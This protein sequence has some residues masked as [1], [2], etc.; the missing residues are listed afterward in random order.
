M[1]IY[2]LKNDKRGMTLIEMIISLVILSILMTST[3]GMITS[4]MSIF[5]STSLAALDRMVGNSVY[6]TLE[7]SLRYATHLTISNT[8]D[9]TLTSQSFYVGNV[10][11]ATNS[12][13]VMY[14]AEGDTNYLSLYSP[15]FYGNRSVQYSVTEVGSDGRHV[16]ITVKIFRDGEAVYTKEATIKCVNLSLIKTEAD[17]NSIE[18]RIPTSDRANAVNQYL[19]FSVDE[20]LLS[21]GSD[22]WALEYK[23]NDYMRGYNAI[24]AEYYG[25]LSAAENLVREAINKYGKDPGS[26]MEYG[27]LQ[28]LAL[29][30]DVAI[31]GDGSNDYYWEG[32]DAKQYNN[33]WAHYREEMEE[34]LHFKPDDAGFATTNPYYGVV[35]T[36]EELYLG[37]MFE[38]YNDGADPTSITKDEYPTFSDP[39]TF[40]NGTIFSDYISNDN[41]MA[42]MTY[43]DDDLNGRYTNLFS[44]TVGTGYVYTYTSSNSNTSIDINNA[45]TI[46]TTI[47]SIYDAGNCEFLFTDKSLMSTTLRRTDKSGQP[48]YYKYKG[49]ANNVTDLGTFEVSTTKVDDTY[50]TFDEICS[51]VLARMNNDGVIEG[52]DSMGVERTQKNIH[53]WD[54]IYI[55]TNFA[56]LREPL[57]TFSGTS[58]ETVDGVA[59]TVYTLTTN[60]PIPQDFFYYMPDSDTVHIIYLEADKNA[61]IG[62]YRPEKTVVGANGQIKIYVNN[63]TGVLHGYTYTRDNWIF[64][65]AD[66]QRTPVDIYSFNIHQYNDWIMYG[67][68]WNSWFKPIDG[69]LLDEL[70]GNIASWFTGQSAEITKVNA[71]NSKFALGLHSQYNASSINSN[72]RSYHTAWIVYN[73]RRST[74]YY[75]PDT[76]NRISTAISGITWSSFKDAPIA[77]DVEGWGNSSKMISDIESRKLSSSG[78]FGL[79][80]TTSDYI[81]VPLPNSKKVNPNL[82]GTF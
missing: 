56:D 45:D 73:P 82:A 11:A 3:L 32:T 42:I 46:V 80:D 50:K 38:Y 6:Q 62:I 44:N 49:A 53:A 69:G 66:V 37:F 52:S 9:T 20:M 78:L 5:S 65:V 74:W 1:F 60:N 7:S 15:E 48:L 18:N 8:P 2:K 64:S 31:F 23:V 43:F 10:D 33:L 27:A 13:S 29:E 25:K 68:D 67:V 4:S 21:G 51:D 30:R 34:Y 58:T 16:K 12:G 54:S 79:I 41:K 55:E 70:V 24:L 75:I 14:R 61:N 19:Y 81:W 63:A 76:T 28:A 17:S 22:A 40:F 57:T 47:E 77:L 39:N 72:I 35:A 26:P 59:C 36:K 71:D